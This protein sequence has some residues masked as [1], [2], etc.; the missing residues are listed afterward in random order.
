LFER[1]AR[2]VRATVAG[3][4]FLRHARNLRA[5]LREASRELDAL[6]RGMAG[7]VRIGA[8]PSWQG[9]LLPEAIAAF[10]L[11]HAQVR[12]QVVGG[13]DAELKARLRAGELDF[14]LAAV[15]GPSPAA[16]PD[17][18]QKELLSDRYRVVATLTH[19][20]RARPAIGPAELL[21]Y[22]W[23]LPPSAT[24]MVERLQVA[25]RARG[26]PPPEPAIETDS[27][28][29]RLALLRGGDYLSFQAEGHLAAL[30]VPDIRPLEVA[31]LTWRRG[32]GIITRR[33]VEPCPAAMALI[34]IITTIAAGRA[35]T[36]PGTRAA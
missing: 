9:T 23:I 20:L 17:L 25:F 19:P 29:L 1:G 22:P 12:I 18:V 27:Q 35:T 8:G 2:G 31:G 21:G 32:S 4:A 30:A 14:V 28:A 11:T 34:G 16:M 3:E 24:Y 6:Q 5:T 13:M 33:A 36:P 15:G 7:H 10:R 26:L